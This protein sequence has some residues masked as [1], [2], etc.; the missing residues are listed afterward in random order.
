MEQLVPGYDRA[1]G[2]AITV[3]RGEHVTIPTARGSV[4]GTPRGQLAK[5][6]RDLRN[7]TNTPNS[8]LQKLIDLNKS[9]YPNSFTK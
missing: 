4:T 1:T 9:T 6:I 2:P 3:P 7:N 5:D 8:S